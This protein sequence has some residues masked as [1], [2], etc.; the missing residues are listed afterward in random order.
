MK[1]IIFLFLMAT[2]V[3]IC[4]GAA[5][6]REERGLPE[7]DI[8]G[9]V[10]DI[11]DILGKEWILIEVYLSGSDIQFTRASLTDTLKDC[12]TLK[13]EGQTVSGTGAPNLFSAPF[14]AGD[15]HIINIKIMRSTLMASI[16]EP[17]NL[18]EHEFFTYVQN[19]YSWNFN[20]SQM[21]LYSKT[22]DG[23]EVRLVFG[24]K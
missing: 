21:E 16:F 1:K 23:K 18:K 8:G 19:S 3:L 12:Y 2:M 14:T 9:K 7:S 5:G 24:L 22:T 17:E 15:N 4:A 10:S 13:F 6:I 20:E 11:N